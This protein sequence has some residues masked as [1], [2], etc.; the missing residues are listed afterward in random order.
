MS[1]R[2]N[3]V[4]LMSASAPTVPTMKTHKR[5]TYANVIVTLALVFAM[6][7]G[8]L[9]ASKYLITSTKQISPKV[10]KSLKGKIGPA[11]PAGPSGPTG[12]QGKE[13]AAG[14]EGK[15]GSALAYAHVVWNGTTASFDPSQTSGMGGATV[16]HRATSAFCFG[17]LPFTA[18]SVQVTADYGNF[19][20]EEPH[21][22]VQIVALG[23]KTFDCESNEPVE[24]ATAGNKGWEPMSFYVV[25]N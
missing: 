22:Q 12:P 18:K 19:V 3:G 16:T 17:G 25:F 23:E 11:G 4:L 14:K 5:L 24:V 10:I 15:A 21:V 8:A 1:T 13:G 9:A 6:S 20:T 2:T 7:G